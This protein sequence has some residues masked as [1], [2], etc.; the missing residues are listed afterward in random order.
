MTEVRNSLKKLLEGNRFIVSIMPVAFVFLLIYPVLGLIDSFTLWG[1]GIFD[2]IES[3]WYILYLFGLILCFAESIDWAIGSAFVL[4][5]LSYLVY[6]IRYATLNRVVYLVFYGLLAFYFLRCAFAHNRYG[7]QETPFRRAGRDNEG[8]SQRASGKPKNSFCGSCGT[9]LS[10]GARFCPV[11]GKLQA[12]AAPTGG[13]AQAWGSAGYDDAG[14][15]S[16]QPAGRQLRQPM[17]GSYAA[18]SVASFCGGTM[19]LIFTIVLTAY[20]FFSLIQSFTFLNIISS[21]PVILM[22]IG[23][24]IVYVSCARQTPN[25]KGFSLIGAGILVIEILTDILIAL[26]VTLGIV[27]M[28][29]GK[30]QPTT[31]IGLVV[32]AVCALGILLVTLYWNGLRKSAVTARTILR[33]GAAEWE[34][35]MYAIVILCIRAVYMLIVLMAASQIRASVSSLLSSLLYTSSLYGG[36]MGS[37]AASMVESV[38]SSLFHIGWAAR[39]TNLLSV[40]IAIFAVVILVSIR[41]R[42]RYMNRV[43]Q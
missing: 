22:C 10:P 23:C 14:N 24:W 17:Y 27:V 39:L 34:T 21:I 3:V 9:A 1:I 31:A 20:L 6:I 5:G 25:T 29:V 4:N 37:S 42:A 28:A 18:R 36:G 35:S 26:G 40:V 2:A 8:N 15:R 41:R 13:S 32:I 43:I 33:G 16:S 7:E 30:S 11:C 19:A 12:G 38:L